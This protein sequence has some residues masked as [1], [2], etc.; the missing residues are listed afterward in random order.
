MK[1]SNIENR[2]KCRY[3][4]KNYIVETWYRTITTVNFVY[5]SK[6]SKIKFGGFVHFYHKGKGFCPRGFCPRGVLSV[7]RQ[8]SYASWKTWNILEFDNWNSRPWIYWN[9]IKGPGKYW[10][11]SLWFF[12]DFSTMFIFVMLRNCDVIVII[13]LVITPLF[14]WLIIWTKSRRQKRSRLL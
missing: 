12:W 1:V 10:N 7:Y 6:N 14:C 3:Q 2:T 13:L 8:G 5:I 4:Y 11:M 9:F